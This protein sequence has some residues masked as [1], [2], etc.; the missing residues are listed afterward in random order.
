MTIS[1]NT[2]ETPAWQWRPQFGLREALGAMLIAGLFAFF[3]TTFL[4]ATACLFLQLP[5]AGLLLL[6]ARMKR[7]DRLAAGLA[8]MTIAGGCYWFAPKEIPW[9]KTFDFQFLVQ[10]RDAATDQPIRDAVV[11]LCSGGGMETEVTPADG[12]AV[13]SPRLPAAGV[14]G[15]F[16]SRG[17]TLRSAD[18][19]LRV[20]AD[21][22]EP[23]KVALDLSYLPTP[24]TAPLSFTIKLSRLAK[25]AP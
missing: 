23:E 4:P 10:V 5:A 11:V 9:T 20:G 16:G 14:R 6:G 17:V 12:R 19:Q 13:L 22:Y 21:D 2:D 3:Y 7:W 25:L 18:D 8:L 1:S 15:V 24:Q